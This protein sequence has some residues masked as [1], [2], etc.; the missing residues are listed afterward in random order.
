VGQRSVLLVRS[1]VFDLSLIALSM[2]IAW[3]SFGHCALGSDP[4][5]ANH[6]GPKPIG[7]G[8]EHTRWENPRTHSRALESSR[9]AH[10]HAL[11]RVGESA[12]LWAG[13]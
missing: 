3:G 1:Q 12:V 5:M 11:L 2:G 13:G 10:A 4:P 7:G 8:A 9:G 6:V